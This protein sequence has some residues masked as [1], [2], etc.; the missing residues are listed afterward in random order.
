M[1]DSFYKTECSTLRKAGSVRTD[2]NHCGDALEIAMHDWEAYNIRNSID[3]YDIINSIEIWVWSYTSI[4]SG[5][6]S[7]CI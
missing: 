2:T 3:M 6:S 1:E 4:P 5:V 7:Y